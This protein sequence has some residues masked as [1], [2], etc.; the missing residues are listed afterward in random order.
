MPDNDAAILARLNGDFRE[1]AEL[2]GVDNA[3]KLSKRF[4]G[5]RV[6]IPKLDG[7]RRSVRNA[8]IRDEYDKARDKMG[9]VKRLAHKHGLT[10]TH[11]YNILGEQPADLT[12]GAL[13]LFFQVDALK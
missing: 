5:E 10:V 13:P 12:V 3:L 7:L 2:I 8:S 9:A 4:G 1:V 6:N 11:I